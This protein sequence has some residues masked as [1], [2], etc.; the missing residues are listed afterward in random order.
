MLS[1]RLE[2]VSRSEKAG[3]CGLF[4]IILCLACNSMV[5]FHDG[6]FSIRAAYPSHILKERGPFAA[7]HC[8]SSYSF[9]KVGVCMCLLAT[10]TNLELY[11]N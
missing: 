6:S 4:F 2:R 3:L 9:G 10:L 8:E 1:E 7:L 5:C 11:E